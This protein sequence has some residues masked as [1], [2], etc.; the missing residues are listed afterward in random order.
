LFQFAYQNLILPAMLGGFHALAP[1]LPKIRAGLDGRRGLLQRVRDFR[2]ANPREL[3]LFHCAS[4]GEFE[5]LKPLAARFD[6]SGYQLAVSYFSPSARKPASS[7]PGFAF[8]D[9]SPVDSAREVSAYLDA[10]CPRLIAITKHDVWPNLVW[11]AR[12]RGIP[13]LL[14]NGNFHPGSMRRWP[15]SR[16]FHRAVYSSLSAIL[17]VSAEDAER[18]R[19]VA[20]DEIKLVVAGDS[21]FDRVW[22]RSRVAVDLPASVTVPAVN[23]TVIVA[24]S[25]HQRDEEYLCAAYRDLRSAHPNLLLLMVPHDPSLAAK[26]RVEQIAARHG[27]SV[28]DIDST[29]AA[30]PDILLINR[31]GMLVDL[32][33]LGHIA[34]VGGAFGKGVHSILEPMAAGLPVITGPRIGVSHEARVSRTAGILRV[35]TSAPQLTAVLSAWLTDSAQLDL[36]QRQARAFVEDNCGAADRIADFLLKAL[37]ASTPR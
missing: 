29:A 22:E 16:G 3:V 15:L 23:R 6:G 31:T 27:L 8:A 18:A 36:L 25:T 17:T 7:F 14:I 11:Q 20:D 24:G 19:A 35:V 21:R 28:A 26:T 32:Y 30:L 5:A 37:R 9:F 10:L 13:V 12:A 1:F 34:Y 4:A 33:R 2:A